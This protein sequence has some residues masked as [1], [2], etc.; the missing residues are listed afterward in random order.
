MN[1]SIKQLC[2]NVWVVSIVAAALILAGANVSA[3]QAHTRYAVAPKK[4]P[5]IHNL[6]IHKIKHVVI[7]MQENCSFDSYFG[8]CPVADGIPMKGGHIDEQR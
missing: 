3:Q 8:T 7:N 2:S 5:A 1:S 4:D 6:G